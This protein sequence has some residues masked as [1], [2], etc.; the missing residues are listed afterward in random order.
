VIQVFPD[1]DLLESL[2]HMIVG[3]VHYYLFTNNITPTDSDVIGTYTIALT[4]VGPAAIDTLVPL[5]SFTLQ[6]VS[7][8]IGKITAPDAVITN[9]SGSP[10]TV[11]G[12][13]G[14]FS[15]VANLPID[16]LLAARFDGAPIVLA[17]GG[18]INITPTLSL[19]SAS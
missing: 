2:Q 4:D 8:H 17:N 3:G 7:G 5:A 13:I 16:V 14:S 10:I 18:T 12:Y 6:A 11:Y 15:T 1:D 19:R 9:N